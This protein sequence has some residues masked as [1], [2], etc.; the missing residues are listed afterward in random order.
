[1][2]ETVLVTGGTGFVAGWCIVELLR[3]GYVV[4]TTVR[5]LSREKAVRDAAASVAASTDR[6]TVIVADLTKDDGWD[7]AMSGC[8]YLL[9]VASP[10]G[11]RWH[12]DV[13]SLAIPAETAHC[14]CSRRPRRPASSVW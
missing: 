13:A 12:G 2:A 8:D 11:Q 9:H 14:A 7:A 3:R 10:L 5:S 1:M 6:L 4:R